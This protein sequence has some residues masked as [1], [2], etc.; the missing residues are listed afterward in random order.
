MTRHT[1]RKPLDIALVG[2]ALLLA[3]ATVA[4]AAGVGHRPSRP[5]QPQSVQP[6]PVQPE[7][8]Q[9][10]N[11]VEPRAEV[12]FKMLDIIIDAGDANLAAYQFELATPDGTTLV[13]VENGEHQA[14]ATAPHYDPAALN[15]RRIIVAAYST[16]ARL[17]TG[18][19]RVCTLRVQQ[20][21]PDVPPTIALVLAADKDGN[22]IDASIAIVANP[23]E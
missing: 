1:P 20:I 12:R 14:F 2:S 3:L 15:A 21:G 23:E 22:A 4:T 13:G 6:G 16:D 7:S 17:P 9:P 18:E 5:V 11:L 19:T 8:V 10:K